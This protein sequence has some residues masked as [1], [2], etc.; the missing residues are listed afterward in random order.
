MTIDQRQILKTVTKTQFRF[1]SNEFSIE[2][3]YGPI[4]SK[5]LFCSDCGASAEIKFTRDA[6]SIL[7]KESNGNICG[8][9]IS[10]SCKESQNEL[11]KAMSFKTVFDELFEMLK[12]DP[13]MLRSI[14]GKQPQRPYLQNSELLPKRDLC[15]TACDCCGN[16]GHGLCCISCVLCELV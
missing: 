12:T 8:F 7:S 11:E 3:T 10:D 9:E 1:G 15:D 6:I 16:G 4:D 2:S 5:F 13:E 14:A